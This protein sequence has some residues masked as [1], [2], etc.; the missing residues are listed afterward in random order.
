MKS[1]SARHDALMSLTTGHHVTNT[2]PTAAILI[3]CIVIIPI[4]LCVSETDATTF[5]FHNRSILTNVSFVQ[6]LKHNQDI[7]KTFDAVE[8]LNQRQMSLD[9]VSSSKLLII[10]STRKKRAVDEIF[11]GVD[12]ENQMLLKTVAKID[13]IAALLEYNEMLLSAATGRQQNCFVRLPFNFSS[14]GVNFDKLFRKQMDHAIQTANTL[15]NMF[16]LPPTDDVITDALYMAVIRALVES[17]GLLYGAA[18]VFDPGH[19]NASHPVAPYVYRNS[20]TGTL[21]VHNI[22]RDSRGRYAVSGTEGYE[23]FWKQRKDFSSLL[24]QHRGVCGKVSAGD[25][26]QLI[27]NKAT[28]VI[29]QLQGIWSLPTFDCATAASWIVTY[30]VPFFGCNTQK[31]LVFK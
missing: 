12:K 27:A 8:S 23:W 15:N 22:A 24:W 6:I 21:H 1:V 16:V 31:L 10:K 5:S 7:N 11:V 20:T 3:L 14:V 18:I 26:A 2:A 29:S 13:M 4:L 25:S 30:S 28:V 17:D 19:H 9:A